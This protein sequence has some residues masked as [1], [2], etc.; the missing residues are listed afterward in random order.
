MSWQRKISFVLNTD[1]S[2]RYLRGCRSNENLLIEQVL[3]KNNKV[4]YQKTKYVTVAIA[5]Y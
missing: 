4:F 2:I 1:L 5:R 3:N